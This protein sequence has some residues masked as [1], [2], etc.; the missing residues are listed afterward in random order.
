MGMFD[1]T[2]IDVRGWQLGQQAREDQASML[3]QQAL[4]APMQSAVMREKF[5]EM[6]AS[7]Q[8]MQ[9]FREQIAQIP[10]QKELGD[11]IYSMV[12]AA[13]KTGNFEEADKLVGLMS[14]INNRKSLELQREAMVDQRKQVSTA[15]KFETLSKVY[16]GVKSPEDWDNA[17][18]LYRDLTGEDSPMA[19]K[20]YSK[21]AVDMFKAGLTRNLP[22]EQIEA[23][24][25]RAVIAEA[26]FAERQR[27]DAKRA[28]LLAEQTR[29]AGERRERLA[30]AEGKFQEPT[31]AN[32]GLVEE[33][34]R[35]Q[36]VSPANAQRF[37]REL[38]YDA[39]ERFARDGGSFPEAVRKVVADNLGRV[40]REEK[41]FGTGKESVEAKPLPLPAS[42]NVKDLKVGAVYSKDGIN[43]K[44]T[45]EGWE[46]V[47]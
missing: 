6:T 43:A 41:M 46:V 42:K 31:K 17:H 24:R 39:R 20:A 38:A 35:Q 25:A 1:I 47:R 9:K 36:G 19:G 21:S 30:K 37:A 23:L 28:E 45:G 33:E 2:P 5:A 15:K 7:V 11:R 8:R 13:T 32:F 22:P 10:Q 18:K 40:R 16:E 44:W 3:H 26:N 14:I 29:A 12:D 34:L 27:M 4:Q